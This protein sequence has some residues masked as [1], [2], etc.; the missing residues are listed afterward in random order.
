MSMEATLFSGVLSCLLA[1]FVAVG[2]VMAL[3]RSF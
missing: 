3:F 2:I 1:A